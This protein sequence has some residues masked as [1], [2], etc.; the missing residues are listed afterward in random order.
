MSRRRV[1]DEYD[2]DR[3]DYRS[4]SSPSPVVQAKQHRGRE[5]YCE[6]KLQHH[7]HYGNSHSRDESISYRDERQSRRRCR[8]LHS[9][10][11]TY[12]RK[13]DHQHHNGRRRAHSHDGQHLTE[14]A[15][16]ALL[17][18]LTETVRAG[19]NSNRS[20]RAVTAAIGAAA[21]DAFASK[22]NVRGQGS[23][24]TKS[25]IGGLLIDRLAN[26]RCR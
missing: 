16:A 23:Q 6:P 1:Y 11:D 2:D 4:I 22:G 21:V 8:S 15:T 17:A 9:E 10:N 14:V 24:I 18:G 3:F 7:S 19:H 12:V 26:G 25:L 13:R 5:F 20:R